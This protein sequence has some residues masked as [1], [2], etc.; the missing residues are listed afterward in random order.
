MNPIIPSLMD[1]DFYS[2]SMCQLAFHKFKGKN[3]KYSY[4]CRNDNGLPDGLPD[5]WEESTLL[6]KT[7]VAAFNEQLDYLCKLKFTYD[8]LQALKDTGVF[9]EDFLSFLKT[10]RLDRSNIK[11][12]IVDNQLNIEVEGPVEQVI[13]F[14]T[15]TLA[16]NSEL[17]SR[18]NAVMS[19]GKDD[20]KT[21]TLLQSE[22]YPKLVEEARERLN[23][24]IDLM[25]KADLSGFAIIDFGT[26]RRMSL[27][28]HDEVLS[29]LNK[30]IPM[31]LAGTSNCYLAMKHGLKMIGTMAHQVLQMYQQ[32]STVAHSQDA[33]LTAWSDEYGSNLQIALSDIFGF[34]AFLCDFWGV[35]DKH[36]A[37]V[38]HDSGNPYMW[39][40]RLLSHYKHR[41]IDAKSKLAVFSDGLT[42]KKALAL[43]ATFY[44]RINVALAIGTNLTNDTNKKALQIVIKLVEFDF[45][46]VAKIA[47]TPGKGMCEDKEFE[48]YVNSIA[49]IK[50]LAVTNHMAM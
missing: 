14:E 32:I 23:E 37:G 50:E 3:A 45:G 12:T 16:I 31:R 10:L 34:E 9:K 43:Y 48:E 8:E 47:D 42:V 26:R 36:Y 38:R 24:K 21:Y 18:F 41:S 39:A 11:C 1:N 46:P 2:F 27:E 44:K 49:R 20:N 5:R 15:P 35:H 17:Y 40:E 19:Q 6:N 13:W 4:K 25:R 28:W 33:A 7:F 29:T 22:D 30:R